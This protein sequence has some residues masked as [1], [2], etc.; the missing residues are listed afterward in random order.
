MNCQEFES[1][2]TDLARGALLETK[3]P[4]SAMSHTHVCERC[5]A[6]LAAERDLTDD[7]RAVALGVK[8]EQ[9]PPGVEESLRKAFHERARRLEPTV[10]THTPRWTG[11]RIGAL[12][13]IAAAIFVAS[14]LVDRQ[15]PE[16]RSYETPAVAKGPELE[17]PESQRAYP[18]AE[19][20]INPQES[21]N[22]AP[23][24]QPGNDAWASKGEQE[25][26]TDF[27]PL[28]EAE[29][30]WSPG[31]IQVVR[32]TLR[33]SALLY[34]GVPV[35]EERAAE[36]IQADVIL[37]EDGTARALRLVRSKAERW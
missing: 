37:G 30:F 17:S 23:S 35:S 14:L 29:P 24:N 18:E 34:L 11:W 20:Y 19:A 31:E 3:P 22:F 10:S 13:A 8:S 32:I 1:A 15:T 26:V 27:F 33:R 9:A 2:V 5:K 21:R 28:L 16:E 12:A 6:R 4:Q 7:L 25:I 36:R